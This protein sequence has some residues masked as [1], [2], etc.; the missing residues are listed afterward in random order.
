MAARLDQWS[1]AKPETATFAFG[2]KLTGGFPKIPTTGVTV[3]DAGHHFAVSCNR[4]T[5]PTMFTIAGVL[6]LNGTTMRDHTRDN[7]GAINI[8][9]GGNVTVTNSKFLSNKAVRRVGRVLQPA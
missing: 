2:L 6:N 4:C 1:T 3:V 9:K 8:Q 7:G 5:W